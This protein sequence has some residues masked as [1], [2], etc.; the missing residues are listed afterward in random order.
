MY[1][2]LKLV[3]KVTTLQKNELILEKTEKRGS[4]VY[5]CVLERKN[6]RL[7]TTITFTTQHMYKV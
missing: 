4:S 2:S 5:Y 1:R 7:Q 6:Y 3:N